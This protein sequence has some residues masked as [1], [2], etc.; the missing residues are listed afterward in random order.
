MLSLKEIISIFENHS[1][2]YERFKSFDILCKYITINN[3]DDLNNLTKIFDDKTQIFNLLYMEDKLS[4][5]H[6]EHLQFMGF[7]TD[8]KILNEKAEMKTLTN[9]L[10]ISPEM[11]I[12]IL[13]FIRGT[14]KSD[15]Q[16]LELIQ[17]VFEKSD[18]FSKLMTNIGESEMARLMSIFFVEYVNYVKCC[19]MIGVRE[20]YYTMYE[21]IIKIDNDTITFFEEDKLY[22]SK[23]ARCVWYSFSKKINNDT[24]LVYNIK[25]VSTSDLPFGHPCANTSLL[26]EK[27]HTNIERTSYIS[28]NSKNEY[29]IKFNGRGCIANEHFCF[30]DAK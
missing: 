11:I 12:D 7:L 15:D 14:K 5:A 13:N 18:I 26:I 9:I 20:E 4:D 29:K 16:K 27:Y 3:I 8:T 30:T 6:I 21:E 10:L 22:Y 17:N 1:T 25:K 24:I 28:K 23:M 2:D 19:Q